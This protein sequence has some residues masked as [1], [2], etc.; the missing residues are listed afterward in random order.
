MEHN[1]SL[2]VLGKSLIFHRELKS[3]TI[4]II[5][6]NKQMRC[7]SS[8]FQ[9]S[10]QAKFS[11]DTGQQNIKGDVTFLQNPYFV[12]SKTRFLDTNILCMRANFCAMKHGKMKSKYTK[13]ENTEISSLRSGYSI[14]CVHFL[15]VVTK[16][17]LRS[18][19]SPT[20]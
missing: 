7:D 1:E 11:K 4:C 16:G 17:H 3:M 10:I 18:R 9:L 2:N 6:T 12:K 19:K 8:K 5:I 20:S 15:K 14:S 13:A